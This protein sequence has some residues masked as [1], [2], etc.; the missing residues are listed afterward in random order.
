MLKTLEKPVEFSI[1]WIATLL[2]IVAIFAGVIL[3]EPLYFAVPVA[4]LFAYQMIVDF[5]VIFFLLLIATPF[6]IEYYSSSGFSTTL[7]TEPMMII[8]MFTFIFFIFLK[9]ELFDTGF[10]LHPLTIILYVHF[11]W[12][13]VTTMFSEDIVISLKYMLAKT[14]YITTFYFMT[15]LVI[16][17]IATFKKAFWCLFVP[18]LALTI[19]TLINHNKYHFAFSEVNKTMVPFFRNHVNYAV[20]LALMLPMLFSAYRWYPK[21]TWQRWIIQFGIV[22]LIAGIYFSYT[23]SSWL[24]VAGATIAFFI[25]RMNKLVTS[26]VF[27]VFGVII[28]AIVMLHNNRYLDYAPDYKK[29]IYHTNFNE[30]MESTMSL[31]DVSS[32]ERIYRWVAAIHMIEDKPY[33]GFGPG[34]FYF[35]YKE[36]TVNKFETYISKNPERSTVHNYYLQVTTE[37]G[38][39][40]TFVWV[41]L[42]IYTMYLGQRLYHRFTNI[43]YKHI[44]MSITLSII[45]IIINLALSDLVEADKIGTS[46]FMFL[47]LL[48]SFDLLLRRNPALSAEVPVKD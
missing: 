18:T 33:M 13:L 47:S 29:T 36:Y 30:H 46:F 1:Y 21:N 3:E 28:F 5:R 45:T 37:Q 12:M 2:A 48:V 34:Q 26:A 41:V 7:P 9:R 23:R 31:E 16:K 6:S 24:S 17:D 4:F 38:F 40:G 35:N 39:P 10:F 19:Y 22:V 44:S 25:I 42:L 20:F 8:F 43:E 27:A 14:W 32:A 15:S 11:A